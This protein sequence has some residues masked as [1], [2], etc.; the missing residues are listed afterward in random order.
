M[1]TILALIIIILLLY[2]SKEKLANESKIKDALQAQAGRTEYAP[3]ERRYVPAQTNSEPQLTRTEAENVII[4]KM[5][6]TLTSLSLV[7]SNTEEVAL[8]VTLLLQRY[9]WKQF[10]G[11]GPDWEAGERARD[12]IGQQAYF[13]KKELSELVH[14]DDTNVIK[15][16]LEADLPFEIP[17]M[18]DFKV[19]RGDSA[20]FDEM[21]TLK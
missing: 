10:K 8:S 7:P 9:D 16:I 5:V 18:K 20:V 11:L 4:K 13:L 1:K 17:P 14:S 12:H 21:D 19:R 15:A 6:D 3:R 2:V